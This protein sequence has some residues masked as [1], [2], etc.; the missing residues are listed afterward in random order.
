MTQEISENERIFEAGTPGRCN[1]CHSKFTFSKSVRAIR[2][3]ERAWRVMDF[4]I[5]N[6]CGHFDTHWVFESDISK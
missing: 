6:T 5:T 1:R 3:N 2:E 4:E